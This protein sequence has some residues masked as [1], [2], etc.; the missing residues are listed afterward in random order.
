MHDTLVLTALDQ[1]VRA[2][3]EQLGYSL[4]RIERLRAGEIIKRAVDLKRE[5]LESS[6][7]E[8]AIEQVVQERN[9]PPSK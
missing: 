1:R 6:V 3:M 4:T 5:P 2:S 9:T 7:V 8:R